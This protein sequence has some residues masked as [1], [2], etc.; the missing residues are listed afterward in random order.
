M[1]L[2][3]IMKWITGGCEAFLGIPFIGGAFIFS[4]TWGALFIMFIL[5]MVTL[6]IARNEKGSIAGN[7]LGMVTSFIGVIPIIGMIM[8]IIT[9][10]VLLIDAAINKH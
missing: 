8:H 7:V 10:I 3:R 9:A 2:S 5:H 1:S 6:F 4:T